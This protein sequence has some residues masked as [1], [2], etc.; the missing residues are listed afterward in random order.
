MFQSRRLRGW[1]VIS[2]CTFK[3][4]DIICVS[5]KISR[6][7]CLL[8]YAPA[9]FPVVFISRIGIWKCFYVADDAIQILKLDK[10][11]FSLQTGKDGRRRSTKATYIIILLL[12]F[13]LVCARSDRFSLFYWGGSELVPV[14]SYSPH[15]FRYLPFVWCKYSMEK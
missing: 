5:S 13:V 7:N 4:L 8:A 2:H 15:Q 12:I 3:S 1:S 6:I 10:T 11:K 9:I 14:N